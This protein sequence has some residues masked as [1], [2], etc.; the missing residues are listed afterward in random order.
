MFFFIN[1]LLVL[2]KL[3]SIRNEKMT[4]NNKSIQVHTKDLLILLD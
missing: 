4:K 2:I 1:Q 3:L